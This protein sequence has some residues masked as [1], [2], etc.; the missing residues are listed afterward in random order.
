MPPGA[1]FVERERGRRSTAT[2]KSLRFHSPA[3]AAAVVGEN[4]VRQLKLA[5]ML[6]RFVEQVRALPVKANSDITSLPQGM[7]RRIGRPGRT[8]A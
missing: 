2:L 8:T 3:V 4:R 1:L 6:G 7:D 5:A